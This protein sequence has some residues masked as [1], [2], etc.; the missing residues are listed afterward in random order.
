MSQNTPDEAF[1]KKCNDVVS[2][3]E[4]GEISFRDV[5]IHLDGFRQEAVDSGHL[6][7][8]AH[9]ESQLGYVQHYR[10]N[11]PIST[12]HYD[13][14]RVLFER[15]GSNRRVMILD[16]NRGENYR[17]KGDLREA[18]RLYRTVQTIA[19]EQAALPVQAM[20]TVN[21]ALV[22]LEQQKYEDA[23]EILEKVR[24]LILK[25]D[26]TINTNWGTIY[27][28]LYSSMATIHLHT[29]DMDAAWDMAHKAW[30]VA[31]RSTHPV[32]MGHAN[33]IMA[34]VIEH[35]EEVPDP[36]FGDSPDVYFNKAVESFRE[37][38]ADAEVAR[39]MYLHALSLAQRGRRTAAARKLQ[40]AMV[41]FTRLGMV[42][43]AARA[44]EAQLEIM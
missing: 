44:A 25:H 7:N 12:K 35:M 21:E 17:M 28:E 31:N 18:L 20:A 40:Q 30:L 10:G 5:I 1:R 16:L 37:I 23:R 36:A 14:S 3:W 33:R 39:T 19:E 38:K 11:L 4:A 29:G 9:V 42:A 43:S 24:A 27:C 2:Q 8:E 22:L 15:L 13:R 41:I 32:H 6:A 34:Q 26:G